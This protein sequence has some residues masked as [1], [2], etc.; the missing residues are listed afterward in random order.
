MTK[1][2]YLSTNFQLPSSDLFFN[3]FTFIY[4][5][6]VT[7]MSSS[8]PWSCIPPPLFLF[9]SSTLILHWRHTLN[10]VLHSIQLPYH[11]LM[12]P[13]HLFSLF[14]IH[15]QMHSHLIILILHSPVTTVIVYIILL[16]TTTSSGYLTHPSNHYQTRHHLLH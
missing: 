16:L 8:M 12:L 14:I 10:G 4:A 9:R 3:L 5:S 7:Y 15:I 13:F 11:Q 6:Y 2:F 1:T